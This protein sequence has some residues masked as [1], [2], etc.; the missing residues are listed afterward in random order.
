MAEEVA[1]AQE[2]VAAAELEPDHQDWSAEV[3]VE[4]RA[5]KAEGMVA[6]ATEYRSMSR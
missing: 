1:A 3:P 2:V 5:V 4:E 6:Q